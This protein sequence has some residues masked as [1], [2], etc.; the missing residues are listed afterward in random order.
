MHG[1]MREHVQV[2]TRIVWT[3]RIHG[4]KLG[5]GVCPHIPVP[6]ISGSGG[7]VLQYMEGLVVTKKPPISAHHA[8]PRGWPFLASS[9]TWQSL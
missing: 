9:C 1:R 4:M 8:A 2:W 7:R 5:I 6:Q 3:A